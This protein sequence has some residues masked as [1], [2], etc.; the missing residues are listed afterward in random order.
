MIAFHINQTNETK[1]DDNKIEAMKAK[2]AEN[3]IN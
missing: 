1:K 3:V 2:N